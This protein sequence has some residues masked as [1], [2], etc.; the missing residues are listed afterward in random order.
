MNLRRVKFIARD[1]GAYFLFNRLFG[2]SCQI[3]LREKRDGNVRSLSRKGDIFDG[4]GANSFDRHRG[5][6]GA[7]LRSTRYNAAITI[8]RRHEGQS[9]FRG[10]NSETGIDAV[11]EKLEEESFFL[12]EQKNNKRNCAYLAPLR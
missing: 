12:K 8:P 5:K 4:K 6:A 2:C 1:S 9:T 10:R 7:C 11:F 3:S